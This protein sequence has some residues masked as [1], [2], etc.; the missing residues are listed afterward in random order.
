MTDKQK[1]DALE[2]LLEGASY[3][4]VARKYSLSRERIRQMFSPIMQRD[5]RKR[6]FSIYPN[7][8]S[9]LR[10]KNLSYHKFA[11][12]TGVSGQHISHVM[13]GKGNPSKNWID[14]VL[15]VT[16]MTY[17]ECFAKEKA[18]EDAATSIKG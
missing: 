9:W 11:E 7:F 4:D 1:L 13:T 16:G 10:E 14:R 8:T 17:E 12:M 18:P 5:M 2:M 6:S 15:E 3:S